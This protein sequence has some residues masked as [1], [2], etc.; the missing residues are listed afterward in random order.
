MESISTTQ[1]ISLETRFRVIKKLGE[2]AGSKVLKAVDLHNSKVVALKVLDD[3]SAFDEH[4][5]ERFKK[6][7]EVCSVLNHPNIV[8]AFEAF[9]IDG[10]LAFS[11][12]F[13]DGHDLGIC[14]GAREFNLAEIDRI[15]EQLLSALVE[16]HSHNII[17]RDVKLENILISEKGVVKLTDLGLLK[18]REFDNA[19]DTGILL[20]T[21]QYMPPE[22]IQ[23][24]DYDERGD[25]YSAGLVLYELLR[26]ERFLP[27]LEGVK[28]L[29]YLVDTNFEMPDF[30]S[31]RLPFKY[32]YTL[33]RTV[34][35]NP[36]KRFASANEMLEAFVSMPKEEGMP[37]SI[38][39]EPTA[40]ML[41]RPTYGLRLVDGARQAR[42][43][44]EIKSFIKMLMLAVAMWIIVTT[45]AD[46]LGWKIDNQI[47][48][49][50]DYNFEFKGGGT[51][52]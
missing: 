49:V 48:K 14:L 32:V 1:R 36:N 25:L 21:S 42:R 3:P 4:T 41:L 44:R 12:E 16:L 6:E 50:F 11:M 27:G 33:E 47:K 19:T 24:G 28:A 29:Q 45:L 10:G 8:R 37:P 15:M 23:N 51:K 2:G 7:F 46:S 34:T 18:T 20:G 35:S 43:K 31:M 17:H 40:S 9:K 5:L 22:Y 38:K 52:K 13:V 26:R 39:L 30:R